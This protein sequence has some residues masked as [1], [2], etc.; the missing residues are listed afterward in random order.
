MP[1]KKARGPRIAGTIC[2]DDVRDLHRFDAMKLVSLRDPRAFLADFDCGED[3][4]AGKL[5]RESRVI[6]RVIFK[7][8]ADFVLVGEDD[9]ESATKLA[10][11]PAARCTDD[12]K[13]REIK[14]RGA[15]SRASRREDR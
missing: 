12:F 6:R 13:R 1:K 9:V 7:Q 2:V 14:A 15:A 11:Q 10:E 8:C 3:A 4:E 5:L